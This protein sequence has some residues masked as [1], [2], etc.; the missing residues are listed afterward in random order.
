[1]SFGSSYRQ[2]IVHLIGA[3]LILMIAMWGQDLRWARAAASLQP[4]GTTAEAPAWL[5]DDPDAAYHL[6]R[7]ELSLLTGSV[8][9]KDRFL[10]FPEGSPIPW[11]PFFDGLLAL[12]NRLATGRPGAMGLTDAYEADLEARAAALPPIFGL[13]ATLAVALAAGF[14]VRR[15]RPNPE[16]LTRGFV[17]GPTAGAVLAAL[18][19][20]TSPIAV[21]YGDAGRIDHH[22]FIA[23]LLALHFTMMAQVFAGGHFESVRSPSEERALDAT[24][25]GLTAGLIAGFALLS[26]LASGIFVALVG[27]T[28]WMA[29]AGRCTERVADARRAGMLYFLAAGMVTFVPAWLSPWNAE[30]PWSLVNLTRGVPLALFVASFALALPCWLPGQCTEAPER[31]IGERIIGLLVPPLVALVAF[32]AL[33]GFGDGIREGLAWASR[34]NLFMDVVA[35]SRP[36]RELGDGAVWRGILIDHGWAGLALPVVILWLAYATRVSMDPKRGGPR[37]ESRFYLLINL[38][39]FGYL[40]I[41]QRRFGNSLAVPLAVGMGCIAGFA[42]GRIENCYVE[43]L[44]K[45]AIALGGLGLSLVVAF[46]SVTAGRAL[47]HPDAAALE[48]TRGWRLE[49]IQGLRW[50]REGTPSPGSWSLAEGEQAYGVLSSWSLGHLIEYHARRPVIATNFGSFVSEDNF[51]DAA[52]AL[53]ERD[54]AAFLADLEGLGADYV[55]VT[56]RMASDFASQA[57][58]AELAPPERAA[59][60]TKQGGK[61]TFSAASHETAVWRLAVTKPGE[62]PTYPG[63]E[64]VYASDRY[65][66]IFGGNKPGPSGPVI[67]IWRVK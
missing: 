27:V 13:L 3:A 65:E 10:A 47:A 26:W 30:Q 48:E 64:R 49:L 52:G 66:S 11:P 45:K 40:A 23:L 57:R 39:V 67:S 54:P 5:I 32:F 25:G 17:V 46:G 6:R 53:L 20:A 37:P 29:A 22:V 62:T 1:V 61:K 44:R 59:L 38:L 16:C 15:C 35:E 9:N 24:L 51:R 33:P 8:P 14:F 21:W 4:G 43:T 18:V 42:V 7:V 58:I 2:R 56:A 36:L 31:E 50:M 34:G 55:V 60:F 28:F 12:D 41:E 19:Y 63:L